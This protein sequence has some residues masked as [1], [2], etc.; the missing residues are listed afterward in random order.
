MFD[1]IKQRE[2][3]AYILTEMND[4][5]T[6]Q[7]NDYEEE[8]RKAKEEWGT[9]NIPSEILESLRLGSHGAYQTVYLHWRKPI[10]LLLLRLT[11]SEADAEDITQDVFIKVWENHHK[12]DPEKNI[13][14]LLYLIARHSAIKHFDKRK[15]RDNYSTQTTA[16][17]I[18]FESSYDIVVAKETA[19]LKEAAL[20]RMPQL[21]R[22]IYI[23]YV[24]EGLSAEEIAKRLD[25][26][27]ETVYNNMSIVRKEFNELLA[28]FM[29]FFILP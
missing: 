26:K 14:S 27:K 7:S 20:S 22:R 12:V 2:N 28:L 25:I 19:L 9:D 5:M 24:E 10:Y 6:N 23:M 8:L 13:K 17:E 16:D 3:Y 18:D 1:L 29:I 21:R 15:A 11:G 4:L